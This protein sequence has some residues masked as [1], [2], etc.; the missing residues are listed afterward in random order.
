MDRQKKQVI[1]IGAGMSGLSTAFWLRQKGIEATVLE[2]S[3]RVGGVIRSEKIDGYT[4]DHAANCLMNFLPE[5]YHL[6]DTVGLSERRVFRSD[7]ATRRYMLKGGRPQ[8]VPLT[9]KAMLASPFWPWRAKLRMAMEPLVPASRPDTE[10]TV[11]GF[12]RRRFGN[13]LLEQAIEPF[14]AGTLAGD[15]EQACVRSTMPKFYEF[16]Q[17][18]GSVLRGVVAS[19][20]AGTRTR[21]PMRLFSFRDGMESLP[22]A[23]GRYLG[24]SLQSG[25]EVREVERRGRQWRI[26]T[27]CDGQ[28]TEVE[29]DT[30]VIATPAPIAAQLLHPVTE[31]AAE[32]LNSI[33]YAP[34]AVM[35][36]GFRSSDVGHNLDGIGCLIPKREGRYLLG[37]LWNS[38]L[39]A[40]RAPKGRVLLTC[41]MGGLSHPD[42]LNYDDGQLLDMALVDL[43]QMLD[44]RGEPEF[45]RV[46]RHH[47]GLPQYHLGHQQRLATIREQLQLAPGLHLCGNYLD[48]VSIRDCVARGRL[49]A[50]QIASDVGRDGKLALVPAAK[51]PIT[52]QRAVG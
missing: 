37:T 47:Q 49:L 16:E 9:P 33:A 12:I 28:S 20:L 43:R 6:C 46:I 11:A 18:Y 30:L 34:M 22:A 2:R 1:I 23:I 40:E 31:L 10:E 42:V 21:C 27:I 50:E 19:K 15:P 51:S 7:T 48:G 29:A 38:S 41:Y 4:I 17:R 8:S 13:E 26:E 5:V 39:F 3:D 35:T 36:L 44:I 45:M 25:V 52:G 32:Q 24:K 14:V